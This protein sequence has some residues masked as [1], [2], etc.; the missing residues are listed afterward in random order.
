MTLSQVLPFL[1]CPKS[2]AAMVLD[3]GRLVSTDPVTR[4][5]YSIVEQIPVLIPEE[6]SILPEAEWGEVMRKSGRD[7]STG[8]P[9]SAS[10]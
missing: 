1:C 7:P 4:F 3:G 2:H 5:C 9:V 10:N 8:H 6:A